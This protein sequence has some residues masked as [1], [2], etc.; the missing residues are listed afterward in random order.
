MGKSEVSEYKGVSSEMRN[1]DAVPFDFLAHERYDRLLLK[2]LARRKL[3][4]ESLLKSSLAIVQNLTQ[5][6]AEGSDAE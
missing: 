4:K 2:R 5:I 6:L 3:R 1:E